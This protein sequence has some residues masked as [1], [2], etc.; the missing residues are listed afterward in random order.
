MRW[1]ESGLGGR[2]GRD[3][4]DD[5]AGVATA[6]VGAPL[7]RDV[8]GMVLSLAGKSFFF[9]RGLKVVRDEQRVS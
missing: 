1:G 6:G 3:D 8:R 9:S 2:W 7:L 5:A 4:D